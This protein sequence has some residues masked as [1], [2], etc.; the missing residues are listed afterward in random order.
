MTT[1]QDTARY[2][3]PRQHARLW[4]IN[5]SKVLG[6]IRSGRLKAINLAESTLGRPRYKISPESVREFERGRQATPPAPSKRQRRQ[7]N[8]EEWV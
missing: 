8:E 4:G 7:L 6:W 3:S 5:P 1:Q 2:L